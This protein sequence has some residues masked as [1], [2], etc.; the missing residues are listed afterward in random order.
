[1]SEEDESQYHMQ[2]ET[3]RI[4][5][6]SVSH[7]LHYWLG[8][9]DNEGLD[10]VATVLHAGMN[11]PAWGTQFLGLIQ[12][13]RLHRFGVCPVCAKVH[14]RPP[15]EGT[16]IPDTPFKMGDAEA[17]GDLVKNLPDRP[18]QEYLRLCGEYNVT[19]NVEQDGQVFCKKCNMRYPNLDDRMLNSPGECSGCFQF[20]SKGVKFPEPDKQ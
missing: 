13:E 7:D 14:E 8:Q 17:I 10:K 3:Q 20:D 11:Y 15:A 12:G 16:V 9:L 18:F 1:V 2:M 19:S 6:E 5:N 4:M